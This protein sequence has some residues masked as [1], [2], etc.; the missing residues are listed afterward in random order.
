MPLVEISC[1]P[2]PQDAKDRLAKKITEI[3]AEEEKRAFRI[4]TTSITLVAFHDIP[5]PNIYLATQ[6][7]TKVLQTLPKA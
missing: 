4:D 2:L 1:P 6:P 3:I 5:A 7:L